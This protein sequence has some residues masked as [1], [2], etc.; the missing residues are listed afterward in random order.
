MFAM[1]S[2]NESIEFLPLE[3]SEKQ[4]DF[5]L[6]MPQYKP[7]EEKWLEQFYPSYAKE[8][9]LLPKTF[10]IDLLEPSLLENVLDIGSLFFNST[11]SW[12]VSMDDKRNPPADEQGC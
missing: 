6:E 8:P 11:N 1:E 2:L 3:F 4:E 7:D 10:S 5:Q 9:E 12:N